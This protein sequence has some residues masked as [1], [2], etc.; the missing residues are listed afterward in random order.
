MQQLITDPAYSK[1]KKKAFIQHVL[2]TDNDNNNKKS[3]YVAMVIIFDRY[4]HKGRSPLLW[5][6]RNFTG[7]LS[8][9]MGRQTKKILKAKGNNGVQMRNRTGSSGTCTW[10]YPG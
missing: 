6:V 3:L 8:L 9:K 4:R 10:F 7:T 1:H 2:S 5:L